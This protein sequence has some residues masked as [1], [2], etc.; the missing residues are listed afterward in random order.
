VINCRR[1][2]SFFA[3][4]SNYRLVE[5]PSAINHTHTHIFMISF[6]SLQQVSLA[7]EAG[8]CLMGNESC[9][10]SQ[11]E[12]LLKLVNLIRESENQIMLKYIRQT[13]RMSCVASGVPGQ[14]HGGRRR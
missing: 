1:N 8:Y 12:Y 4:Q 3:L 5:R 6:F 13:P 11:R 14:A 7:R 2:F 10:R 9:C